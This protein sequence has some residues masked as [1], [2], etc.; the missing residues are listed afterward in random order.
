MKENFENLKTQVNIA[1]VATYLLGQSDRGMYR[2]PGEHTASLKIYPETNSFYDFG[3]GIGGDVVRLWSHVRGVDN[4]T[5]LKQM[6]AQY[7]ISPDLN[8]VDR[9]NIVEQIRKQEREQEERKRIDRRAK[10]LWC[11]KIDEL[12]EKIKLCDFLLNSSHI[13]PLSDIWCWAVNDKQIAEY[14][15]DAL[16]EEYGRGRK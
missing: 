8:E 14:R 11:R 7:G 16:V 5:A 2:F 13:F 9:K 12:Q 10:R 3:R 1:D 15:M 6:S 4:W